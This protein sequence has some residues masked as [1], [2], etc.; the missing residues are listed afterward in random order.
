[1]EKM[2]NTSEQ[3]AAS[4]AAGKQMAA[5]VGRAV[6][7]AWP[8]ST[9]RQNYVGTGSQAHRRQVWVRRAD[10][11]VTDVWVNGETN[12]VEVGGVCHDPPRGVGTAMN[13]AEAGEVVVTI[14]RAWDAHRAVFADRMPATVGGSVARTYRDPSF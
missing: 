10:G 14:W 2:M 9:A 1:M 13:P 6:K 5:A 12:M 3:R 4:N 8:G 11:A 7:K